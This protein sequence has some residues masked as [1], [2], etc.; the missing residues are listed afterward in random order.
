MTH[1]PLLIAA[2]ALG[3]FAATACQQQASSP[4]AD[5]RLAMQQEV[6]PAMLAIWDVGNNALDD[7]GGI[8][9][10]KMDAAKWDRVAAEAARLAAVGHTLADA[11]GFL[12]AAPDNTDVAEGETSMAQVQAHLDGDPMGMKRE[13]ASFAA[14]AD[15]L[16][17]AAK[18]RDAAA[19]GA[20]I[21]EMD[22]VCE[23][24]HMKFW[25]PEPS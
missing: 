3:V 2:A 20:L 16:V 8:D 23:S 22:A 19:A 15:K 13:A 21:G 14:H 11:S 24:C 10:A 7:D 4:P 9:P 17:A 18:A 5:V 1:R 12:A 25:Y 6:N